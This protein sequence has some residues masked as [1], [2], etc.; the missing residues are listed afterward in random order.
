MAT[1]RSPSSAKSG[2][3]KS[4]KKAGESTAESKA[5]EANQSAHVDPEPAKTTDSTSQSP[6][7]SVTVAIP[8]YGEIVDVATAAAMVPVSAA[9]NVLQTRNG[10]P[11][12]LG[13]A[14]VAAV[15]VVE[16]PVAAV[17]GMGLAYM[18]RW[19]P[20]RPESSMPPQASPPQA[21]ASGASAT[22]AEQSKAT[23]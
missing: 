17:A 10:V 6:T 7:R 16:W 13:I 14:G 20:L 5:A 19:G 8:S 12:Y 2:T 4:A 21:S 11:L 3:S 1:T 22:G 15:G 18:R 9:R 23:D